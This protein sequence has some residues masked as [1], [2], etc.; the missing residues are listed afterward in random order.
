[1]PSGDIFE[2]AAYMMLNYEKKWKKQK[3]DEVKEKIKKYKE[4]KLL[5]NFKF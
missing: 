5:G 4:E 2:Y 3:R 1:L